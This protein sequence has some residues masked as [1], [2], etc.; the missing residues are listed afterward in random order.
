[1]ASTLWGLYIESVPISDF[2]IYYERIVRLSSGAFSELLL[3]KSPPTIAYY[4]AFHWLLGSSQLA[5]YVASAAAW[6]GGA[7]FFYIAMLP[8]MQEAWKARILYL[9]LAL[10][11]ALFVFSPVVSSESVYFLLSGLCV[12]L[13]SKHVARGGAVPHLYV[14]LGILTAALFLTRSIGVLAL[15]ACLFVIGV[16]RTSFVRRFEPRSTERDPRYSRHPLALCVIVVVAFTSIWFA[17]GSLS[18]LVGYGFQVT[19]SPWG[20]VSLLYGTNFDSQ[21]RY[22]I[23]D[24]QLAGYDPRDIPSSEVNERSR[25]IAIGRILD[26]PLKFAQ[27]SL[28]DKVTQL[29]GR[30]YSLY[31]WAV[32]SKERRE[33]LKL[34]VRPVI[35]TLLDGV[36]RM[37]FLLFLIL[38]IKEIHRPSHLLILG[39]IV[40]LYSLPHVF[41]EAKPRYHLAMTPF[42]IVGALLLVLELHSRRE[43]WFDR[44]R[45]K[46]QQ[47]VETARGADE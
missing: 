35:Y 29:W 41:L 18:W 16:S 17:H 34:K 26:D 21:G 39:V 42:M 1:M 44:A 27:F 31:N 11:P 37:T 38:L 2:L 4:A 47:V 32:A 28:T 23:P 19:A 43:E 45:S 33:Q 13:M 9:G 7:A 40:F 25:K 30:E 46:L 6:T 10:C 8:F 5:N 14:A 24:F 12:W 3:T 36:Y 20:S 15:F 22:N